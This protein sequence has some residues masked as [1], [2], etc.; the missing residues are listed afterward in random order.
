MTYTMMIG[1]YAYSSWSMRGWMMADAFGIP[2]RT[3]YIPMYSDNFTAFQNNNS[4][5]RTVPALQIGDNYGKRI[6]WDSLAIAETLNEAHPEAGLWP[7]D[8]AMRSTARSLAAEMHSGF[9][10]LRSR[11]NMNLRAR[12]D[13]FVPDEAEQADAERIVALWT[14]AL[15]RSGGPF[16]CG[17]FSAADVMFAPVATRFVTYDFEISATAQA[18]V[19]AVYAHPSFRRWHACA[20]AQDRV[21]TRYHLDLP[22]GNITAAPRPPQMQAQL[23]SG[24]SGDAINTRC[25]YSGDPVDSGSLA[26]INGSVVGFCNPFCCRKSVADPQA[27]PQLMTLMQITD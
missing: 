9:H 4:P 13:G 17:R 23:Y 2:F 19:N 3:R 26:D 7:E 5:A 18:Y 8:T 16:L 10:A 27:W 14:W 21:I 24:P 12:Y 20:D 15:D 1:E 25:P 11:P 22:S 6:V